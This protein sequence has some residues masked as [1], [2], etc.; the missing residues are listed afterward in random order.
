MKLYE[1]LEVVRQRNPHYVIETDGRQ[2][3][4]EEFA[5]HGDLALL[6]SEAQLMWQSIGKVH[7]D[8]QVGFIEVEKNTKANAKRQLKQHVSIRYKP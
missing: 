5:K 8:Q 4:V 6:L 2:Y 3:T 7:P 1:C